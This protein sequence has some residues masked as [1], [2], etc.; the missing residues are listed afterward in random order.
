MYLNEKE[1]NLLEGILTI[2]FSNQ[3]TIKLARSFEDKLKF[4]CS[5]DEILSTLSLNTLFTAIP[6]ES[7]LE[8]IKSIRPDLSVKI[9][10]L[11]N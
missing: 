1:A 4:N 9:N 7:L 10:N 11:I 5:D 2:E 3:D 8:A 6:K